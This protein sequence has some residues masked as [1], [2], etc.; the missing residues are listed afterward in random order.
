MTSV[1]LKIKKMVLWSSITAR[2]VYIV[3]LPVLCIWGISLIMDAQVL[4]TARYFEARVLQML[5][6]LSLLLPFGVLV[7]E[8]LLMLKRFALKNQVV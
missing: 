2:A 5:G 8:L 6:A 3:L 4:G 1:V 7:V